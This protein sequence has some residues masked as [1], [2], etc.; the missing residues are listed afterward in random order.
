MTE[1]SSSP[2]RILIV[3]DTPIYIDILCNV[4]E[5]EYD[6]QFATS[7]EDALELIEETGSPD[8]ILLDV[9]MPGMDGYEVCR[10]LKEDPFTRDITI[11]FVSAKTDPSE[12]AEGLSLGAAGY[13]TKPIDAESTRQQIRGLLRGR[14]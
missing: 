3:D 14:G 4:L 11:I 5:D 12:Q 6:L 1:T 9:L 10:R 2:A 8:M 13:L 7:G